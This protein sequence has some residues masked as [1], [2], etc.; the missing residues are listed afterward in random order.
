[1]ACSRRSRSSACT[2]AYVPLTSRVF[3]DDALLFVCLLIGIVA[4]YVSY[5]T[6]GTLS[7]N[8]RFGPYGVLV[9]SEGVVRLVA[10]DRAC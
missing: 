7:G 5:I 3:N 4:Y 1:M 8:G 2:A 6:Q 9:G 10:G